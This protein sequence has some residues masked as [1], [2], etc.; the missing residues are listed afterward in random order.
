MASR[1]GDQGALRVSE[2]IFLIATS[3]EAAV[4]I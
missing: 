1:R 2:A 3:P 4:Q